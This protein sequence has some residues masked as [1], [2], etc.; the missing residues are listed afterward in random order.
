MDNM[1]LKKQALLQRG[2]VEKEGNWISPGGYS[3]CETLG[4][5][6]C[7]HLKWLA[8]GEKYQK[9]EM[10]GICVAPILQKG[11]CC[12]DTCVGCSNYR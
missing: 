7:L 1:E 3:T 9:K 11:A 6:W 2:W 10:L 8:T 12:K 5:A 4:Y